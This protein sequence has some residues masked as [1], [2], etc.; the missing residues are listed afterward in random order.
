MQRLFFYGLVLVGLPVAGVCAHGPQIQVTQEGG[1]VVTRSLIGDGPYSDSATPERSVYVMPLA[2]HNGAWYARPN[3]GLVPDP[4]NPGSFAPHYYSGPGFA[5]GYGA[6]FDTGS[7]LSVGFTTGLQKW[8]GAAFVDAGDAQLRGF[9]GSN[10]AAPSAA[11]FTQDGAPSLAMLS[12]P[13]SADP[14]THGTIRYSLEG[15]A[16][17]LGIYLAS[18]SL[19]TS[20]SGVGA[21]DAYHFVLFRGVGQAELG[22]A[23]AS[24]GYAPAL[25]QVVPEPA[26]GACLAVAALSAVGLLR[27]RRT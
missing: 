26:A 19:A 7:V 6:T 10:P 20:Q 9:Q 25:V 3:P 27:R 18:L 17:P 16:A 22:A 14:E 8:D 4:L 1:K 5:P 11:M 21:S 23:V 24:L 13:V 2:P 12:V 15:D